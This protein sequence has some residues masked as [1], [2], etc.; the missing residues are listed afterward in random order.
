MTTTVKSMLPYAW[1]FAIS[2]AHSWSRWSSSGVGRVFYKVACWCQEEV[3]RI[4]AVDELN[5]LNDHYLEDVGI[6]RTDICSI[7]D[8]TV[9]RLRECRK[10]GS[11]SGDPG[12]HACPPDI[13]ATT[14]SAT[15]RIG[16]WLD[17][18]SGRT[19]A[20]GSDHVDARRRAQGPLLETRASK[21]PQKRVDMRVCAVI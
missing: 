8:A 17:S 4:A 5:R 13:A 11:R 21:L 6:N 16:A 20:V 12:P 14:A 3:L 18:P 10:E 9:K 7:V 19:F 1:A 15:C 2:T